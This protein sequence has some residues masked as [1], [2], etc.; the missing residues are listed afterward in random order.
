M[1]KTM[2]WRKSTRSQSNSGCVEIRGD[3]GAVQDTKH[4]GPHLTVNVD[5]LVAAIRAGQIG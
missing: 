4:R 3:L 2:T 1:D 5:A